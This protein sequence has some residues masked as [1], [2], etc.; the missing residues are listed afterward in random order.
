MGVLRVE[1]ALDRQ[2]ETRVGY[3]TAGRVISVVFQGTWN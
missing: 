1:D 3:H 2:P